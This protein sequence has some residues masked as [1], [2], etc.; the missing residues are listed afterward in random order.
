[1]TCIL[2]PAVL[3]W[4]RDGLSNPAGMLRLSDTSGRPWVGDDELGECLL[5][6]LV[7]RFQPFGIEA[8][9]GI[10]LTPRGRHYLAALA[11]R[12]RL[13]SSDPR[14]CKVNPFEAA[15]DEVTA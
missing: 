1:M 14:A 9:E 4:L 3:D 5:L 13:V 8:F 2:R 12:R 10:A 6:G 15:T 7:A 11:E